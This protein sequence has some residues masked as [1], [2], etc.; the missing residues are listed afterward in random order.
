MVARINNLTIE[1]E[2]IEEEAA[3][4]FTVVQ[5]MEVE[6]EREDLVE[7]EYK[8]DG[9]LRAL[10]ALEFLTKDAET[11]RTMIVDARNGFN[12]MSRLAMLWTMRHRWPAGERCAFNC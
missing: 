11:T 12:D 9:N 6:E 10:G 3:E 5:E 4:I 8:G 2:G 1:T 7:G